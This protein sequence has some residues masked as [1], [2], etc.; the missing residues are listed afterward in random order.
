MRL[1]GGVVAAEVILDDLGGRVF[2]QF[3]LRERRLE[4]ADGHVE[5]EFGSLASQVS[6]GERDVQVGV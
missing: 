2:V 4:H 1:V 6:L 5:S 3:A